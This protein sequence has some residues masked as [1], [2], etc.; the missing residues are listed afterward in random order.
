MRYLLDTHAF[1]WWVLDDARLSPHAGATI[2]D[3]GNEI[4]FSAASAWEI[5]TKAQLGRI[6][7]ERDPVQFIPQQVA[8]NGF[9]SLAIQSDHALHVSKLPLYHRDPSDR[10]L[11]AQAFIEEM[12]LLTADPTLA[13]Y[14]VQ[15][16]W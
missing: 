14:G 8:A 7:F 10:I 16:L 4:W 6:A 9:R 2:R 12:I 1:L 5:A 3:P 11:V 15:V 13:Q